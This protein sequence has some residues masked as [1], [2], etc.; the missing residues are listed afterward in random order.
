MRIKTPALS[1]EI[2]PRFSPE[3]SAAAICQA[4]L[5]VIPGN[6]WDHPGMDVASK[7][8]PLSLT[9]ILLATKMATERAQ[10]LDR[11][12]RQQVAEDER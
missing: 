1:I 11:I 9:D 4:I 10:E 5:P 12:V 7:A 6:T 3:V 8:V 2:R